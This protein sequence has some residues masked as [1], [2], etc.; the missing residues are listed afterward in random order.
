MPK[1]GAGGA[2]LPARGPAWMSGGPEH[3]HIMLSEACTLKYP[4]KIAAAMG[5]YYSVTAVYQNYISKYFGAQGLTDS[6]IGVL[7]AAP[8][9]ISLIAQPIWGTRGDRARS[10]NAVFRLMYLCSAALILS[11]LLS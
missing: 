3:M 7:M 10:K 4:A 11:Y 2:R 8:P 9:L 1:P 5:A 6:E